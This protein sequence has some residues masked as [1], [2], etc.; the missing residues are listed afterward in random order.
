MKKKFL[1]PVAA[2]AVSFLASCSN[3]T[4]GTHT[5]ESGPNVTN[6]ENVNGN[7]PDTSTGSTLNKKPGLD[8]THVRDTA[9]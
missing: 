7:V 9:K 8:S 5:G 6:M 1:L 2:V 4:K 3:N